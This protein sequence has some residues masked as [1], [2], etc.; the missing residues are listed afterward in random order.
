[1]SGFPPKKA[2]NTKALLENVKASD[3][4]GLESLLEIGV[5]SRVMVRKNLD[6]HKGIVNGAIGHVTK[7]HRDK[8]GSHIEAIWVKFKSTEEKI[9]RAW[10]LFTPHKTSSAKYRREQFPLLPAYGI[11]VHKS[12]GLTLD[13]VLLDLGYKAAVINSAYVALSRV[14]RLED[15]HIICLH[16]GVINTNEKCI[17][18]LNHDRQKC[19]LEPFKNYGEGSDQFQ[20]A[21]KLALRKNAPAIRPSKAIA[22]VFMQGPDKSRGSRGR[23]SRGRSRGSRTRGQAKDQSGSPSSRGHAAKRTQIRGR[24]YSRGSR[25]SRNPSSRGRASSKDK[26][27]PAPTKQA[28]EQYNGRDFIPFKNPRFQCYANA[29]VQGLLAHK[30]VKEWIQ[31]GEEYEDKAIQIH[32]IMSNIVASSTTNASPPMW[33]ALPL[34]ELARTRGQPF[35]QTQQHDSHEFIIHLLA[36]VPELQQSFLHT[37]QQRSKCKNFPACLMP[38][39]GEPT[40]EIDVSISRPQTGSKT[41]TAILDEAFNSDGGLQHC[42]TCNHEAEI[43]FCESRTF[44]PNCQGLILQLRRFLAPDTPPLRGRITGFNPDNVIIQGQA[45]SAVAALEHIGST[46]L[47]FSCFETM[48]QTFQDIHP[49]LATTL[50][51][52][53]LQKV[54]G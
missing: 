35:Q 28:A 15:I 11:T 33:D 38:E 9:E 17:E 46:F 49:G 6:D 5:G 3:A 22:N 54:A 34:I 1:M 26:G 53:A 10:T 32:D 16:P 2:K 8:K 52:H 20:D 48:H 40:H 42:P 7:I 14:R 37:R 24:H 27:S 30:T 39:R 47:S 31:N 51:T 23:G 18:K 45:F 19:G 21:R 43:K 29:A 25:G 36:I 4:G 44:S 12:Q 50:H 13:A 41:F